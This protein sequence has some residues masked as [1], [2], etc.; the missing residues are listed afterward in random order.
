VNLRSFHL[1]FIALSTVLAVLLAAWTLDRYVA[2][3]A[4]EY[5]VIGAISIAGAVALVT[6]GMAFRHRSRP[7]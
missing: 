6:Y 2:D 5:A 3:G 4:F 7:W 1:L